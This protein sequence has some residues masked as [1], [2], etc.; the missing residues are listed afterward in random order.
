MRAL[1]EAQ[2]NGMRKENQSWHLGPPW[3]LS[4]N[5]DVFMHWLEVAGQGPQRQQGPHGTGPECHAKANPFPVPSLCKTP[6]HVWVFLH[7]QFCK[8]HLPSACCQAQLSL[9]LL[10]G[11]P[12]PGI[13]LALGCHSIC[14][15]YCHCPCI[16][17]A[18]D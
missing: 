9:H 2:G 10:Q 14:P 3:L 17:L 5:P 11:S 1:C 7:K 13:L 8:E 16:D 15:W 12:C 6:F 18:L 4:D